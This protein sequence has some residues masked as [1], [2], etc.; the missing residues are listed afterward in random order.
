MLTKQYTNTI[1][2]QLS[3]E[4]QPFK[5]LYVKTVP[6]FND[7]NN[8]SKWLTQPWFS[9]ALLKTFRLFSG[10]STKKQPP[11]KKI[12]SCSSSLL[13]HLTSQTVFFDVMTVW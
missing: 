1:Y 9:V 2:E 13:L 6:S 12:A 7:S 8:L 11:P 3:I 4:T 10:D 5:T